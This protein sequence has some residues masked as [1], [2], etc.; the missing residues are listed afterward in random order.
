MAA[1]N[2]IQG[3]RVRVFRPDSH[4]ILLSEHTSF[5]IKFD[6]SEIQVQFNFSLTI[7]LHN[8]IIK[9][10][11]EKFKTKLRYQEAG[12]SRWAPWHVD[13]VLAYTLQVLQGQKTKD[14]YGHVRII[15]RHLTSA[16]RWRMWGAY[17]FT[18]STCSTLTS[19][20]WPANNTQF[21][22]LHLQSNA[23]TNIHLFWV[24]KIIPSDLAISLIESDTCLVHEFSS[25]SLTFPCT[26]SIPPSLLHYQNCHQNVYIDLSCVSERARELQLLIML[27]SENI[28][29]KYLNSRF[30]GFITLMP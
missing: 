23:V 24:E 5:S 1:E 13:V 9:K 20:Q 28:C 12:Q 25:E 7:I 17:H 4:T 8:F 11:E 2:T 27:T 10:Q 22:V 18:L 3:M 29:R 21:T 30:I 6:N 19:Q 15:C 14:Y 16:T 26:C